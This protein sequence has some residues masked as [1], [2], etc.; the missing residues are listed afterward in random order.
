[1]SLYRAIVNTGKKT[2]YFF[3]HDL[4]NWHYKYLFLSNAKGY[5]GD[6]PYSIDTEFEKSALGYW[7]KHTG[8]KV[9]PLWHN[10]YS[11]CNGIK[12]VRYVPENIY[13]AYIEPFYNRKELAQSCDDKCYYPERFPE[14]AVPDGFR[15]PPVLLRNINGLFFDI[16][17]NIIRFEDAIE[18]ISNERRGY[19]IKESITGSGGNRIIFVEP[20]QTKTKAE[21]L[22]I[23]LYYKKDF[24]IEG[25]VNQCRELKQLNPSSVNTIRFIT[26]LDNEGVHLLSSVMRIGGAGSRTDNFSTGGM[27]CG[28]DETGN[29][30]S[31]GYDQHYNKYNSFHPNG[32]E[33]AGKKVPSFDKAKEL[34]LHLHRRFG[35][36]RII[37]WD[38][39]IDEEYIPVII[40]FNLTPQSIDFHQINNGPLFGDMTERVLAEVFAKTRK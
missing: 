38:V 10:Y 3:A 24:V 14:N 1:M 22:Q 9:N 36:F 2:S 21:L 30:K 20:G 6:K 7:K 31:V 23:Y 35:H 18:L 29:L 17:F 28:I 13:Y 25:I 11:S 15:R 12:D 8:L 27:A 32:I 37:S 33:F 34:V 40:E 19:V 5:I 16:D 26:Y 39:A 4:Q